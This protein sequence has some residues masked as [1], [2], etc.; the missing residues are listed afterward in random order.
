M[1]SSGNT[2]ADSNPHSTASDAIEESDADVMEA[3]EEEV[4]SAE[5]KATEAVW[6][7][8]TGDITALQT[9]L[10]EM[11]DAALIE[12]LECIFD[13]RR[14]SLWQ[15][16]DHDRQRRLLARL[17]E[18]A[19]AE[20]STAIAPDEPES[21][22]QQV[23]AWLEAGDDEALR[24]LLLG[25]SEAAIAD[26]LE[27]MPGK[28]RSRVWVLVPEDLRAE[29]L[30]WLDEGVH[31]ALLASMTEQELLPL[32]ADLDHGDLVDVVEAVSDEVADAILRSLP[33]DERTIMETRL[34]YPEDSAGR[35]MEAEWVAVRADVTLEVVARFLKRR[36]S[37]P[38]HTDGLMVVDREGHYRGKL[39]VSALLT[40]SDELGVSEVMESDVDWVT[41]DTP[42]AE[43]ADLFEKR[44]VTSVAVVDGEHKLI[45][46]V[47]LDDIIDVIRAE[48]E[49]PLLHMRGLDEEEDLFAPVLPSAKRR[50]VWLGINLVTAFLAAW[51][52]GLFEATL[53]KVVALA[54]LMPIVASMG[55]IAGSQTLTLAIRGLALGQISSANT[56][57]L[58]I[59]EV[60]I[61]GI[62]GAIWAAVVAALAWLWF[63]DPRISL[64]IAVAMIINQFAA[65]ISG[66]AVPLVL[67][68]M[69]IDP[70]LSGSVILTTVTDVVGFMSFLGLATLI[71]L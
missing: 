15:G 22:L 20:L 71:L 29:V 66:L 41:T 37:L 5:G 31:D 43:V 8:E 62:N 26:L 57:W 42:Q 46:R 13:E 35:L 9:H 44:E 17:S 14:A 25:L 68:R 30:T 4:A 61:A 47:T 11:D 24:T 10:G 55:G 32:I 58:A 59:K 65:S 69:G 38:D 64:V 53:D 3:T 23:F 54:V 33:M 1:A 70:A 48:A 63:G 67:N 36:G 2:P 6:L 51:V 40:Q 27:S 39:P 16:L 21:E 49:A 45:G 19:R 60:T 50:M 52:I 56:R 12:V 18:P 34:H 7:A 28:E